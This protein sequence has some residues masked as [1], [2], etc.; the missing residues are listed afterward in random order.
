MVDA[1]SL[2]ATAREIFLHALG[3]SSIE[4]AFARHVHYDRGV[5]RVCD[6]L[7]D[8]RSYS[9]VLAVSFGKAGHRMAETLASQAGKTIGGIIADPNVPA[10]QLPGYRYFSGGHPE[11]NEESLRGTDA[12]LKT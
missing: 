6:D 10:H 5:L 9:R 4:K 11:P 2:R 1:H 3:E 12:L 8:L 7:Y